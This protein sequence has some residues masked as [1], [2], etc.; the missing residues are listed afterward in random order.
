VQAGFT[1][2]DAFELPATAPGPP[3]FQELFLGRNSA[4]AVSL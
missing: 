2:N 1:R 4:L 3:F